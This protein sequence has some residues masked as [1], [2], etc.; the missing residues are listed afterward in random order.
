MALFNNRKPPV[1]KNLYLAKN[2]LS[3]ILKQLNKNINVQSLEKH[4]RFYIKIILANMTAN[5]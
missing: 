1:S 5:R 3:L 4:V 2:N